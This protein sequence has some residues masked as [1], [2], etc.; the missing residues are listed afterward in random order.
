MEKQESDGQDGL[1]VLRKSA[2]NYVRYMRELQEFWQWR[3]SFLEVQTRGAGPVEADK[4]PDLEGEDHQKIMDLLYLPLPELLGGGLT[5]EDLEAI[6][7]FILTWVRD[8]LE[9]HDI[10]NFDRIEPRFGLGDILGFHFYPV[11]GR[12][13][14]HFNVE[15][16][17]VGIP[18][19][20]K[21]GSYE[22][23]SMRLSNANENQKKG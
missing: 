2:E 12:G 19:Y 22:D 17:V 23:E 6:R 9:V 21:V 1:D 14:I 7:A 11:P 13:S 18:R 3:T 8:F 10:L 16:D 4:G 15:G 5:A 20:R